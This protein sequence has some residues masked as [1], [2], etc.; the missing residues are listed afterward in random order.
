MTSAAEDGKR[1]MSAIE[2]AHRDQVQSGDQGAEP[3]GQVKRIRFRIREIDSERARNQLKEQRIV[4]IDSAAT[5]RSA[6]MNCE[7]T[8]KSYRQHHD[9]AGQRARESDIEE[10]PARRHR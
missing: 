7:N 3:G 6:V 2:L 1:S 9:K 5:S 10:G 4:E 8:G